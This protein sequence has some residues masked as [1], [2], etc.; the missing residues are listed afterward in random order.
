MKILLADDDPVYR[1]ILQGTVTQ[2]G[3]EPVLAT[4]GKEAWEILQGKD[5]PRLAILDWV[6]P[7]RSG[8]E[9]CRALREASPK[10]YTYLILLTGKTEKEDVV[11]GLQAGADD[12]L[13]KPFHRDELQSRI[14]T[15]R[16]ILE[17]E[18]ELQNKN[19]QIELY[20]NQMEQLAETRATQLIHAE[21][22]ATLGVLIA[23]IMHELKNPVTS[24]SGFIEILRER[25]P[26]LEAILSFARS[27]GYEPSM[28]IDTFQVLFTDLLRQMGIAISRIFE[29]IDSTQ[30][31]SR[32]SSNQA[33]PVS[34]AEVVHQALIVAHSKLKHTVIVKNEIPT[35][36]PP[37]YGCAGPLAQ[38]FVNL[39]VNAADARGSKP[40]VHLTISACE[41]MDG[42]T[43]LVRVSDDG[44]GMSEETQA[45]IFEPFF[46]TK[47]EKE[48]TGLGLSISRQIL[49]DFGGSIQCESTLG[50]GTT[51]TIQLKIASDPPL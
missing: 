32:S 46:T 8:P 45:K 41:W 37:V 25:A 20:A 33:G 35:D 43:V 24:L 30:R 13:S 3:Y 31:F 2:W 29:I 5:A 14:A 17:Y 44:I 47:G 39:F 12:F 4:N 19:Q 10:N 49:Q 23:E 1:T 9:I 40:M 21:R 15:G 42:K 28:T 36:L 38:V 16:R 34:L 6:M 22:L 7:E 48:G 11:T 51:F 18:R 26:D 50:K 27:H